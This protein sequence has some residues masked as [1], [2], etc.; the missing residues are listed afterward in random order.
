MFLTR[1]MAL[2][3]CLLGPATMYPYSVSFAEEVTRLEPVTVTGEFVGEENIYQIET[4]KVPGITPDTASLLQKVPGANINRNGVLTGI[5]QYRG[6]YGDRVNVK[7]NG[8]SI[9]GAGP[10]AMDTPLSYLPG[11]Q[12]ESIQVI[13]GIAPVSSGLETIGGTIKATS[14]RSDFGAGDSVESQ[15]ILTL[16]GATV[17]DAYSAGGLVGL[18]NRAH[19]LHVT[20]SRERGDDIE[21]ES[22]GDR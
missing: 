3:C 6:M 21:F 9:P 19:R 5:A 15:G 22:S 17:N 14:I 16:S 18:A 2:A 13:R 11:T 12:L 7:I 1:R 20:G 10:N 8:I 4:E